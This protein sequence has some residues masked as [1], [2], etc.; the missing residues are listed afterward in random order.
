MGAGRPAGPQRGA[1]AAQ[2]GGSG[3]GGGA[4]RQGGTASGF[5]AA[6]AAPAQ[7]PVEP[8]PQGQSLA[9]SAWLLAD[10]FPV[11]ERPFVT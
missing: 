5:V 8:A 1:A 7:P 9:S 10:A 3:G 2:A 6:A 11:A 4:T